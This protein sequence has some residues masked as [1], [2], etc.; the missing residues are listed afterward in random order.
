M[1]S[2][3]LSRVLRHGLPGGCFLR[4]FEESDAA[5]LYAL[6]DANRSYLAPWLPWVETTRRPEDVLT[7]IRAT[8]K[9]LADNN[10]LGLAIVD[11][12]NIIG[13]IGFHSVDWT[14][15]ST[16]I[17]YWLAQ[18]HQGRG[19]ATEAVRALAGHAFDVWKLN[20][21]E[22]RAAVGN[23]RSRA[24][25]ERLGFTEEGVLRQAERIGARYEDLVVYSMLAEDWS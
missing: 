9:Q 23:P 25:P 3:R 14:H 15:R 10:G 17:G 16:S 19:T 21:V 8:R 7:F 18:P 4:L 5:E 11:E 12:A 22:I 2:A 13:V 1:T 20:R 6:I 24:I